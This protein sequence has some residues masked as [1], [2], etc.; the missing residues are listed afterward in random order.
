MPHCPFHASDRSC[1]G[2]VAAETTDKKDLTVFNPPF[3][4]IWRKL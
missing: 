1:L 3:T 2:E 4:V